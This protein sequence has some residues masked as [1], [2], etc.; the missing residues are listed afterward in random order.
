MDAFGQ[1]H[2]YV[3]GLIP[4]LKWKERNSEIAM[5][6]M[7]WDEQL[8]RHAMCSVVVRQEAFPHANVTSVKLRQ[9]DSSQN[10]KGHHDIQKS[11]MSE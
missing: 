5:E 9:K 7:V 3:W 4:F 6:A 1:G 10:T 11:N 8:F 2:Y